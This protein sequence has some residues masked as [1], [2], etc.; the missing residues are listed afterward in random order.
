MCKRNKQ[1]SVDGAGGARNGLQV[2]LWNASLT[3]VN[4]QWVEYDVGSVFFAYQKCN[5]NLCIDGGNGGVRGNPVIIFTCNFT[6]RNQNW[7][8]RSVAGGHTR[9]E[10]RNA[11]GFSIDGMGS[12]DRG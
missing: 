2:Y 3:N 6:N 11:L 9:L 12:A 8:K 4:Q 1:F 5:T 10:K 7:R